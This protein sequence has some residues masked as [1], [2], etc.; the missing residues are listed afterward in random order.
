MKRYARIETGQVKEIREDETALP[1][2]HPSLTWVEVTAVIPAPQE[3]WSYHATTGVFAAPP[4]PPTPPIVPDAEGFLQ[5]LQVI[6]TRARLRQWIDPV[7]VLSWMRKSYANL[8]LDLDAA[9]A[10]NKVTQAEYDA[11][12]TAARTRNLP[13]W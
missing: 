2:F 12:V 11:I 9:K 4:P 5:D 13:G 3:G 7:M 10:A 6:F 1:P 8:K